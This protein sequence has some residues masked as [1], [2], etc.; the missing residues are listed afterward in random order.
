MK[1]HFENS[2]FKVKIFRK[3]SLKG[4]FNSFT[5]FLMITVFSL[6][7]VMIILLCYEQDLVWIPSW[8]LCFLLILRFV[9]VCLC[10]CEGHT[11]GLIFARQTLP[12]W[13]APSPS[14]E[15]I[16]SPHK[17]QLVFTPAEDH[18]VSWGLKSKQIKK[19]SWCLLSD[20]IFL[21]SASTVVLLVC[22]LDQAQGL[23]CI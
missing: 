19:D 4:H 7:W 23:F 16:W 20:P 18:V 2:N 11:Q 3:H 21:L 22:C 12:H 5:K 14:S 1:L 13:A 9:C 6:F 15:M 17:H 8:L 10:A